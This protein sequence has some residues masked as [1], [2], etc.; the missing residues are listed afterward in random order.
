V[1]LEQHI[2]LEEAEA[3]YFLP[4]EHESSSTSCTTT[5]WLVWNICTEYVNCFCSTTGLYGSLE[6]R[7]FASFLVS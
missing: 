5:L 4:A 3:S 6:Q 2:W 7:L 1:S